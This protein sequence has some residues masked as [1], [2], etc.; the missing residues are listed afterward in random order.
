MYSTFY[1]MVSLG[2]YTNLDN[3]QNLG[4]K[5]E[6]LQQKLSRNSEIYLIYHIAG[7]R[8]CMFVTPPS[9]GTTTC[10]L[11]STLGVTI[12]SGLYL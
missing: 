5:T 3:F 11:E 7:G 2:K 4:S 8:D 9:T 12:A 10:T 1:S 6:G